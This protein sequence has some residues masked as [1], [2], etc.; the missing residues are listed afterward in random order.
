MPEL[1]EVETVRQQ[2]LISPIIGKIVEEVQVLHLKM[3]LSPSLDDFQQNL[4]GQLLKE[5]HR[6][7]KYLILRFNDFDLVIHLRM[8][9]QFFIQ[10]QKPE[11]LQYIRAYLKLGEFYLLF[12]DTRKF[13]TWQLTCDYAHILKHLGP[14]PLSASFSLESF[15]EQL[16]LSVRPIKA[17]L[18]DQSLIAGIGN[19][20]ADESLWLAQI[21]PTRKGISLSKEESE[22]LY[23]SIKK[24]LTEAIKE[25]GSSLGHGKGNFKGLEK[26]HGKYQNNFRV[27]QRTKSL[28]DRCDYPIQKMKLVQ[29]GTHYCPNCQK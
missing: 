3:L 29:R 16:R 6:R 17:L 9:G 4:Q 23:H 20:Y 24:I 5:I 19:I 8:T 26:I 10:N 28:C 15:Y 14:E 13:G 18:L 21:L 11:S 7:G 27:Y 1:P 12:H 2:L 25:N 22:R